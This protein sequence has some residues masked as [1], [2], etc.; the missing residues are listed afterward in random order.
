MLAVSITNRSGSCWLRLQSLAHYLHEH[1]E[2][3]F[4]APDKR[5]D[6]RARKRERLS[7]LQSHASKSGLSRILV[8][9]KTGRRR[10][11]NDTIPA[12]FFPLLYKPAAIHL[13]MPINPS[14]QIVHMPRV[15]VT[16]GSGFLGGTVVDTLLARGYSVVTTV[17]STEKAQQM[18]LDRPDIS[19]SQLEYAIVRDIAQLGAFDEAIQ[20]NLP[21]D[22]V[23]HTA[24]PFHYR[25]NDVK[26]DM[27]D[28][29][30]NG[31]VGI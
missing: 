29:A 26:R 5:N 14:R 23:I 10:H 22:A 13:Y 2:V 9:I 12:I 3:V 8:Q 27:L 17:R 25:I 20:Q 11:I 6:F 31:T 7:T 16:G 21:L 1:V 30:V 28:P 18:R 24:S 4:S 15:L 19:A